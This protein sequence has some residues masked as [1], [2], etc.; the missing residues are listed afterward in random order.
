IPAQR[1]ADIEEEQRA[2]EIQALTDEKEMT[3]MR[4]RISGE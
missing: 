1:I 4:E 2:R 3:R